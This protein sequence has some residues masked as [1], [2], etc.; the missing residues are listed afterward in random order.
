M[1]IRFHRLAS[2][3]EDRAGMNRRMFLMTTTLAGITTTAML[4]GTR[5]AAAGV[6]DDAQSASLLRMIQDIYPHP[7]VLQIA[8]YEPRAFP[9]GCPARDRRSGRHGHRR[10]SRKARQTPRP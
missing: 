6:L 1:N 7:D 5:L 10:R 2:S 8:H 9:A 4:H 3:E